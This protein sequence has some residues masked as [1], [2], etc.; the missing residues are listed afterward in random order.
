MNRS[1][2][3]CTTCNTA[4]DNLNANGTCGMC[5]SKEITSGR[6]VV[7]AYCEEVSAQASSAYKKITNWLGL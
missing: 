2:T 3:H 7:N 6:D 4:T 5:R 1:N